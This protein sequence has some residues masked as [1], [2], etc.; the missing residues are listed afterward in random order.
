M[1]YLKVKQLNQTI[2]AA[3]CFYQQLSFESKS[4][5]N[6]EI[7]LNKISNIK[8]TNGTDGFMTSVISDEIRQELRTVLESYLNRY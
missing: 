6:I 8:A 5:G 3:S 2:P 7:N 1:T 4:V